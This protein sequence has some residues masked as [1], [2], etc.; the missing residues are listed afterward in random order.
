MYADNNFKFVA[1]L[2]KKIEPAKLMNALGHMAVGLTSLCPAVESMNFH[3]YL[4]GN[5]GAHPAISHFPFIVLVADN[6]NKIRSARAAAMEAGLLYN[7]FTDTMLGGSADEQLQQ[8]RDKKEEELEY[9]GLCL[10]GPAETIN[11]IT[12]KFSLFR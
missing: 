12:R 10:F 11:L 5:G 3:C 8:T 6:S 7:D 2:N 9:F 4:D 1:V